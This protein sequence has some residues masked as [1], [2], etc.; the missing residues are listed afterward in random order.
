M[1]TFTHPQMPNKAQIDDA[2]HR[3]AQ[4]DDV[5]LQSLY[6]LTSSSI[7]AYALS[8]TKSAHDAQDIMHD[9]FVKVYEKAHTY[10]S[11]G[12]PMAW[13]LTIAKNLCFQRFRQ[14]SRMVDIPDETLFAQFA[15]NSNMSA[16]DKMFLQQYLSHLSEQERSI[17][18]LHAVTG[19]KH[20]EIAKH[21]DMPLA[22]VL[23]K[24]HRAIKKLKT[25]IKGAHNE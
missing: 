12:K 11:H 23:S 1:A 10:Q 18:V 19:L 16:D 20:R 14:Q 3:I 7:Y 15:D 25:I 13:I 24:Y 9:T 21:L 5:A 22:T 8:V 4:G 6:E 17:V 2:L